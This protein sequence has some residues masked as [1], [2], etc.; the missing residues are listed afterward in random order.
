MAEKINLKENNDAPYPNQG[1]FCDCSFWINRAAPWRPKGPAGQPK[2]GRLWLNDRSCVGLRP[3]YQ[4]H[5][6][7]YDL[8]HCRTDDGRTFR[9]LNILDEFWRERDNANA[10]A[11]P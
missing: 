8:V 4:N 10:L 11:A 9:A 2:E 3:R 5:V 1:G 6:W 7:S